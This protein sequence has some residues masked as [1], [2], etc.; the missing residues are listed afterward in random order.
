MPKK[1]KKDK[2][3]AEYRRK[4]STVAAHPIGTSSFQEP[5]PMTSTTLNTPTFSFNQKAVQRNQHETLLLDPIEFLAIKRDLII[6]LVITIS[7][8]IGQI[9][10]WRMVG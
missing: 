7:I 2:I 9:I 3:I 4:L 1:T 8:L 5:R 6:T 10:I